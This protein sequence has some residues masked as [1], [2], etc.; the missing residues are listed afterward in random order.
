VH[1]GAGTHA[2]S[3][4]ACFS[5]RP[6]D[7]HSHPFLRWGDG[8][9][10]PAAGPVKPWPPIQARQIRPAAPAGAGK[11][12]TRPADRSRRQPKRRQPARRSGRDPGSRPC[13][14]LTSTSGKPRRKHYP[15]SPCRLGAHEDCIRPVGW[16]RADHP[17]LRARGRGTTMTQHGG[18]GGTLATAQW[19]C[20][21]VGAGCRRRVRAG[22][23]HDAGVAGRAV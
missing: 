22:G 11:T 18:I 19:L 23:Q 9:H 4:S 3:D 1:V 20:L 10:P 21:L 17:L 12:G 13:A 15:H 7:G 14:P 16:Q 2:T 5:A 6:H 8:T